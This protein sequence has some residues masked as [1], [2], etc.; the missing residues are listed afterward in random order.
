[1]IPY[2]LFFTVILGANI[3][4]G[5]TGFAGTI[6]AMPFSLMLVGYPVAKPVLNVL[7][8]LSGIYVFAGNHRHVDWKELKRIVVVMAAGILCGI[9]IRDLFEGREQI[10]YKLLGLFV[11]FLAVQGLWNTRPQAAEKAAKPASPYAVL[12]L[13]VAGVVHGIFVSGGPLLIGYLTKKI[14]DKVTFRATIST[15]WVFLNSLILFD[16][17]RAGFWDL[18]LLKIQLIALPFF[19]AGMW[20]GSKLYARMS[21]QLFMKITYVLLFISGV[22]LLV[23]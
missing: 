3:I 14:H 1:M 5:I 4:Q 2:I 15:V 23:K 17:I 9:L 12:I 11:I 16:D 19:L 7:G 18:Q 8:L 10:L 22:S 20:T 21:Q 6:L 13:P